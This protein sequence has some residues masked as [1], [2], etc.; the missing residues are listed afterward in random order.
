MQA[1][2]LHKKFP[3]KYWDLLLSRELGGLPLQSFGNLREYLGL[4]R[5]GPS[6]LKPARLI[7][8]FSTVGDNI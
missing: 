7:F 8:E 5:E 2:I 4:E 6:G 1:L 3:K